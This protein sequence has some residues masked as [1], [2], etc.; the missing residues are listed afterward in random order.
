MNPAKRTRFGVVLSVLTL[1]LSFALPAKAAL[2]DLEL[3]VTPAGALF[4]YAVKVTNNGLLD[5]TLV[6]LVDA[7]LADPTIGAT[8]VTPAGFL[9]LYDAGLGFVDFLEDTSVFGAGTTVGGFS[10]SSALSP[11]TYFTTFEALDVA[12]GKFTGTVTI[13]GGPP[14][15]VPDSGS[16]AVLAGAGLA[17]LAVASRQ[18][19]RNASVRRVVSI[20]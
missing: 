20:P 18:R 5:L 17:A 9:G 8:L 4:D 19:R 7:P 11:P 6:T 1:V 12:G 3:T 15:G 10:F 2:V 14:V 13:V 16:T